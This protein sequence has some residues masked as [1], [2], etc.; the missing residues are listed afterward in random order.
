MFEPKNLIFFPLL[1]L[2]HYSQSSGFITFAHTHPLPF[3]HSNS[4][5]HTE[6]SHIEPS[7]F[8][9]QFFLLFV[10]FFVNNFVFH[11]KKKLF[12]EFWNVIIEKNIVCYFGNEIPFICWLCRTKNES[13]YPVITTKKK[14]KIFPCP[15]FYI[16]STCMCV[17]S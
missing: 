6:H 8:W 13:S 1:R 5:W 7:L 11:I 17:S 2:S 15:L 12:F 3:I 9:K 4:N 14:E 10:L 16:I